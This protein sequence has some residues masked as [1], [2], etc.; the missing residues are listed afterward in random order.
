MSAVLIP[1]FKS[2]LPEFEP[3]P[4]GEHD[5]AVEMNGN[6]YLVGRQA[7]LENQLAER[8]QYGDFSSIEMQLLAKA[9]VAKA[10][11]RA[12]DIH[13][14]VAISAPIKSIGRFRASGG[15]TLIQGKQLDYLRNALKEISFR[16]NSTGAEIQTVKVNI[17]KAVVISELSAVLQVIPNK[18]LRYCLM[19]W[20]HG[21]LQMVCVNNGKVVGEP[22]STMGLWSA[23]RH[24]QKL[25]GL[26]PSP[27][28]QA[29]RDGYRV[30]G[31]MDCR[32]DCV[33]EIKSAIEYH[34]V[35]D[36]AAIMNMAQKHDQRNIIVSGGT[37]HNEVAMHRL[38]QEAN[39]RRFEIW[40]V[41]KLDG[42]AV[43]NPIN[44][45][46][47]GLNHFATLCLDLGHSAIKAQFGDR[48]GQ[49]H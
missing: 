18:Y 44:T 15:D 6:W 31:A 7:Q 8:M 24:F 14:S 11:G 12:A 29:F 19:Q 40:P 1:S 20:G 48:H 35:T 16:L 30:N 22:C 3:K 9:A 28:S 2:D 10:V 17:D 4:L 42:V 45:C 21:D 5:V 47:A 33:A 37:V 13:T 25:S 27:A 36:M 41:H 46:L 49:H 26:H 38:Q 23:V 43:D 39:A 34:I 32:I